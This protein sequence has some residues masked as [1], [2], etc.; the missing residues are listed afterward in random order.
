MW[1]R[2]RW[3]RH[4]DAKCEPAVENDRLASDIRGL[5]GNQKGGGSGDLAQGGG[6][7][8]DQ[9]QHL[10]VAVEQAVGESN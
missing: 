7:P 3:H 2:R 1:K 4:V 9:A 8:A 5:I 6:V 10:L